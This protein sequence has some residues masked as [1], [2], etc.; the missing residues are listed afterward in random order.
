MIIVI[1]CA[2]RKQPDAGF[3]LTKDGRPVY[4]VADPD[5]A[6]SGDLVYARPDDPSDV[7][8]SWRDLLLRY[9]QSG[10]GNPLEL[11]RAF[12]LYGNAV[13]RRL[14]NDVGVEDLYI[15]SAGWGLIAASFLIPT[16]DITFKAKKGEEYRCR[17][18]SDAYR[19]F[20]MLPLDTVEP[21]VFFGGQ[22]YASLFASLTADITAPKTVFYNSA[23]RP[24]LP[25]CL[26]VRFPTTT[27][28]NWQ[29]E[30]AKA[31]LDGKLDVPFERSC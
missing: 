8:P 27:K 19:D 14:A 26:S 4:F 20:E 9:N 3:M 18:K 11:A 7:G 31:F 13:Y 21:I 17:K 12:E 5:R 15:L 30:C 2:G 25:G 29:Y 16:Y 24:E 10:D 23:H 28:T 6:P 1:Q 22:E